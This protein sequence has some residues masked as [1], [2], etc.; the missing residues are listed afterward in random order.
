M[1]CMGVVHPPGSD[2]WCMG[3][4]HK[5]DRLVSWVIPD[6]GLVQLRRK[7]LETAHPLL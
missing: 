3:V 4:V 2:V 1:R 6:P 7:Q 5:Q